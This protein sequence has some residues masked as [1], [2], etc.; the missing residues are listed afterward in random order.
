LR[1]PDDVDT[2]AEDHMYDAIRY[3]VL[4]SKQ[5]LMTLPFRLPY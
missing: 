2:S 1:N 4:A 5:P 3:R